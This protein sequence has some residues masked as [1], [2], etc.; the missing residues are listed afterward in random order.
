MPDIWID[1]DIEEVRPDVIKLGTV[2]MPS[3]VT[4]QFVL[5]YEGNG[6]YLLHGFPG[7]SAT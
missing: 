2:R 6:V 4:I 1:Q 5:T 7:G 3:N